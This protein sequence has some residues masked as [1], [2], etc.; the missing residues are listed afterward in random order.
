MYTVDWALNFNGFS[1]NEP[2]NLHSF[3]L[4]YDKYIADKSFTYTTSSKL[5]PYFVVETKGNQLPHLMGLQK[6]NNIYIKQPD[7]QYEQLLRGEWDIPFLQKSDE[8]TYNEYR[9]RIEF[10]PNLY[11]FLYKFDC[12]IKLVNKDM[13][14]PFKRR[15]INMIFQKDEKKLVYVLELRE[16]APSIFVPTS[17][18]VHRKNAR[19][20]V[21]K[22]S[23]LEITDVLVE[24]NI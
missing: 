22:F 23:P 1:T 20:L 14:S 17:V 6:W 10:L 18:T 11:R 3:A 19:S 8:G 7:K 5:L 12:R 13:P 15:G 21:A 2:M 16:K 4:F 24:S 9:E